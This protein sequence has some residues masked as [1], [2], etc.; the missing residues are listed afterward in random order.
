MRSL[1]TFA[2]QLVEE[3]GEP[4]LH[5]ARKLDVCVTGEEAPEFFGELDFAAAATTDAEMLLES[6]SLR[7]LNGSFYVVPQLSHRLRAA[8][9]R[10]TSFSIPLWS[11]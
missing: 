8:D 6:F 10:T 2:S 5:V 11:A 7:T 1:L 9:H 4:R 3:R